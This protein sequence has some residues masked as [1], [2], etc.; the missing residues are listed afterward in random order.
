[1]RPGEAIQSS[2]YQVYVLK[3]KKKD[4]HRQ[5]QSNL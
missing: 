5:K 2:R 4:K 3:Q 1:M